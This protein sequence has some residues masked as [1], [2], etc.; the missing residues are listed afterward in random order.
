MAK[1][2]KSYGKLDGVPVRQKRVAEAME[3]A[4]NGIAAME[5]QLWHERNRV[6]SMANELRAR[7]SAY[8]KLNRAYLERSASLE[9]Y[10]AA[11]FWRRLRWAFGMEVRP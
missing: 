1:K 6:T 9:T 8:E 11:G 7:A 2:R 5:A 4:K 10:R 3:E